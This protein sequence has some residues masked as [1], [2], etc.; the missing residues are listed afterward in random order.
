MAKRKV[1]KLE[2]YNTNMTAYMKAE[3]IRDATALYKEK[4]DGQEYI[5]VAVKR[6]VNRLEYRLDKRILIDNEQYAKLCCKL[7]ECVKD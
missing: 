1:K 5:P 4:N 7:Y 2:D 3:I 6:A